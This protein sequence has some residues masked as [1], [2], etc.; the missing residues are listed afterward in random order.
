MDSS[1]KINK[2]ENP[3]SES[4]PKVVESNDTFTHDMRFVV[5]RNT[6][7]A[8]MDELYERTPENGSTPVF[9]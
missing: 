6:R 2:Q 8:W 3:T 7:N 5:T 9:H 1:S 4:A